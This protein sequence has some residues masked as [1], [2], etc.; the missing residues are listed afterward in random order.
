MMEFLH[1]EADG[2]YFF[3]YNAYFNYLKHIESILGVDFIDKYTKYSY[4]HDYFIEQI[5]LNSNEK[6]GNIL[7]IVL[8][9]KIQQKIKLIYR[10]VEKLFIDYESLYNDQYV[11]GEIHYCNGVLS[12]EI[13]LAHSD[14]TIEFKK[15][16]IYEINK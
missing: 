2:C 9:N 1:V 14:I 16:E 10:N 7:E 8:F 11:F 6:S 5:R 4:F 15:I 3:N 12:H 13:N